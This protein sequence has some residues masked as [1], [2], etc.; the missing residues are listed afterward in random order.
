MGVLIMTR[1]YLIRHCE[2][3]LNSIKVY[4]GRTDCS[5]NQTGVLQVEQLFESFKGVS[6]DAIISSPLKRCTETAEILRGAFETEITLEPDFIELDFGIWE[7]LH[8]K[9]ISENYPEQWEKWVT[10]WKNT[11]PPKGESFN[12]MYKRVK[13]ALD[14]I[15]NE[16][17]GQNVLIVSHKGCLQIIASLLLRE[18]DRL[19]W[20]FT[21]EHGRYS[22]L[23]L[24]DEIWVVKKLNAI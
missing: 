3:Y 7:G 21:F 17:K 14:K 10:D 22:L 23:E 16:F 8:Y 1:L 5:L 12:E 19:F 24:S 6:I 13:G 9:E 18:D 11:A 4:Y 20:N 15:L 2:T